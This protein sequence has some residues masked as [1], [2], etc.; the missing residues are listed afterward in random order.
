MQNSLAQ[1]RAEQQSLNVPKILSIAKSHGKKGELE[2]A[3]LL[4]LAI[5]SKFPNNVS[6]LTGLST[7][8]K[9]PKKP[10]REPLTQQQFAS[11][12]QLF[13]QD[14]FTE[15]AQ[16]ASGLI[17]KNPA[18]AVLPSILGSALME[19]G[20][21]D[22]GIQHLKVATLLDPNYTDAFSNLGRAC[23][24]VNKF[25]AAVGAFGRAIRLG[26]KTA[27]NYRDLGSSLEQK[28]RN[29]EAENWLLKSLDLDPEDVETLTVLGRV[30]FNLEEIEK[31]LELFG[32]AKARA[33]E[34][35]NV[36]REIATSLWTAGQ[37]DEARKLIDDGLEKYPGNSRL[38]IAYARQT[39]LKPDD[40]HLGQIIQSYDQ[41]ED[42]EQSKALLGFALGK[43]H[44]DLGDPVR[45]FDYYSE[46]NGLTKAEIEDD[47]DKELE[48]FRVQ[49]TVFDAESSSRST[50]N[51]PKKLIFIV[52]MPRSGTTLTEQIL[53]SHSQVFGAGELATISHAVMPIIDRLSQSGRA[54]LKLSAVNEIRNAYLGKIEA[55]N[56]TEPYIV[57]KMPA[58][59]R[60]VGPIKLA[61]PDAHIINMNRDPRAV[62][63]SI[64]KIRFSHPH[65]HPYAFDQKT[66]GRYHNLYLDYMKLWYKH[67][68]DEIL[69][70]K[71]ETLTENQ[72][73]QTERLLEFCELPWEDCCLNFQ[74]TKRIVS[75]ASTAQVR[76]GMYTGSSAAWQKFETQLQPLIDELTAGGSLP[77]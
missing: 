28:D 33:P 68:G 19:L 76:K 63:W 2:K 11:L 27:E 10:M 34:N 31:S 53:S 7:L 13:D 37:F 72:Q 57:D 59:F 38:L 51:S 74:D 47:F 66:L 60:W 21:E 61:F 14:K 69:R 9:A 75:T 18:N 12:V 4:Y 8:A 30:C 29:E 49:S 64:F 39:K 5:I 26:Q 17:P 20:D 46:A 22:E 43:V 52:G 1:S 70:F 62:C 41:P 77:Y 73:E 40:P 6:A 42:N 25:D 32:K 44:E 71:Y 67:F 15:A 48:R 56:V 3:K 54:K 50:A 36:L 45:A 24:K 55:L 35:M 23:L 16:L 58:N 65:G